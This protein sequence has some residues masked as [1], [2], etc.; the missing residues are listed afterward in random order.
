[1]EPWRTKFHELALRVRAM[2]ATLQILPE[3]GPVLL[4]EGR[5]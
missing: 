4:V 2:E 3:D 1:M 5:I